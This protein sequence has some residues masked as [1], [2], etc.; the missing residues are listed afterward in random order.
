MRRIVTWAIWIIVILAIIGAAYFA[1]QYFS[2][3]E[4][5]EPEQVTLVCSQDCADRGQCGEAQSGNDAA[6]VLGGKDGPAVEANQHDVVFL[7]GSAA[8]V[9]GS[10]EATLLDSDGREFNQT[11]SR[12]E[13]LNPMG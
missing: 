4:N 12:V 13:A 3:D 6:V 8:T 11:F 7:A 9:R 10:M 1:W 2:G 5:E